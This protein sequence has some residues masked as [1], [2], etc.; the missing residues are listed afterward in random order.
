MASTPNFLYANQGYGS[1]L[2]DDVVGAGGAL[3]YENGCL[4]V[5]SA[6]GIGVELN[7]DRV[8]TYAELYAR[9]REQ[10]AFHDPAALA[11]TPLMP[12]R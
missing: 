4:R 3:P 10:F 12:K 7:P 5:P 6:P 2:E 9:E 11:P 8:A 1:F